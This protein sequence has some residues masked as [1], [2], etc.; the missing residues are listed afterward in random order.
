MGNFIILILGFILTA[1]LSF[2]SGVLYDSNKERKARKIQK[3]ENKK[4]LKQIEIH[5]P[6]L[7]KVFKTLLK[8][9][10]TLYGFCFDNSLTNFSL[11]SFDRR[12]TLYIENANPQTAIA[13]IDIFLDIGFIDESQ[14]LKKYSF[15]DD[16]K[17]LIQK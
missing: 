3:Q 5:A 15:N 10:P 17:E 7:L 13:E 11:V 1:L 6:N 12:K 16:F 2:I 4:K 8:D 9:D 14:S